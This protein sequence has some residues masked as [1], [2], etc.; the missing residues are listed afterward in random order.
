MVFKK[1]FCEFL[2]TKQIV[3]DFQNSK[4]KKR[5]N[6]RGLRRKNEKKKIGNK[7]FFLGATYFF[8]GRKDFFYD[9]SPF[10]PLV[11]GSRIS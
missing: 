9:K 7:G 2:R 10:V 4:F 5:L 11:R 8:E 6:S 3:T 1:D